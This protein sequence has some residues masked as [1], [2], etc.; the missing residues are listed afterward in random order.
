VF[1]AFM[2]Y[3]DQSRREELRSRDLATEKQVGQ[4]VP[5]PIPVGSR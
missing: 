1:L 5:P 2:A 3:V 4:P